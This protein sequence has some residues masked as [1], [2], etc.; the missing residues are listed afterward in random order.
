MLLSDHFVVPGPFQVPAWTSESIWNAC[1]RVWYNSYVPGMYV[2]SVRCIWNN[3]GDLCFCDLIVFNNVIHCIFYFLLLQV[4]RA[5]LENPRDRTKV[6][7]IYAN[8]TY[9]DILLKVI[10][11]IKFLNMCHLNVCTYEGFSLYRENQIIKLEAGWFHFKGPKKLLWLRTDVNCDHPRW[12]Y[13]Y[14]TIMWFVR[15]LI[16]YY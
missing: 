6:H 5:I 3:S 2:R 9:E 16:L 12:E 15:V 13:Q 11:A 8:V 1:W 14:I 4:A 10:H 7:L